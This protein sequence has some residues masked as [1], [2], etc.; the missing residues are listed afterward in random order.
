M[1]R[2]TLPSGLAWAQAGTLAVGARQ[3]VYFEA[4][5][6]TL[7][8]V[9][10]VRGIQYLGRAATD[11]ES[12]R[13]LSAV[14]TEKCPDVG[15]PRPLHD[16][17]LA[18]YRPLAVVEEENERRARAADVKNLVV[19]ASDAFTGADGT[20]ITSR[21]MDQGF[22]GGAADSW[23]KLSGNAVV[24]DGN[25]AKSNNTLTETY[26]YDSSM[27]DAGTVRVT[28]VVV[29]ADD[30]R[31]AIGRWDTAGGNAYAVN[32]LLV[33]VLGALLI[34]Y[35]ASSGALIAQ[36]TA[37]S[38]AA[39]DELAYDGSGST[40]LLLKNGSTIL[41]ATDSAWTTGKAGARWFDVAYINAWKYEVPG[42]AS[43]PW[44]ILGPTM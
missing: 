16:E 41:T 44:F 2:P 1:L 34:K 25:R 33:G 17:L 40:Q 26:I 14:R 6:A 27:A 30:N 20:D 11:V 15:K 28:I 35:T 19:G 32:C 7:D 23:T 5:S 3:L 21:A 31:N 10:A 39:A 42:G 38:V 13:L 29:N 22:G 9:M 37:Q 24:I 8:R 4:D 18:M 43:Q 36:D 12:A